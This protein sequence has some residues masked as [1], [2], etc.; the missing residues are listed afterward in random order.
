MAA[1]LS[2]SPSLPQPPLPP[3]PPPPPPTLESIR[4]ACCRCSR[5]GICKRCVCV[6]TGISCSSAAVVL[7]LVHRACHREHCAHCYNRTTAVLVFLPLPS[8][9]PLSPSPPFPCILFP[10]YLL[11]S[12]PKFPPSNMFPKVLGIFGPGFSTSLFPPS[13]RIPKTCPA[14][15]GSS[16]CP[17][18]SWL[19]QLMVINCV[20]GISFS[21]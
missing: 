12:R 11:L 5:S 19:T 6:K 13:Y 18:V 10:P 2:P 14:G 1:F 7:I 9:R 8:L 17:S 16:C 15:P 20:G 21:W 3:P 4:R